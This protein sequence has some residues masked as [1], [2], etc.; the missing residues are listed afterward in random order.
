AAS[1]GRCRSKDNPLWGAP[2]IHGELMKLGLQLS[3]A[4]VAKYI[5]SPAHSTVANL[6]HV[7]RE[8]RSTDRGRRLLRRAD[9]YLPPFVCVGAT[10][11]RA[12]PRRARRGHR[13]SD[14]RMDC[15]TTSRSIP[16][17]RIPSLCGPRS[18]YGVRWLGDDREG[19]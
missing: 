15:L 6:A 4:I 3:H 7:P 8:S 2:R 1:F 12:P 11:P 18:R 5:A 13:T 17:G 19:D 16:V 9:R 14:G 10:R